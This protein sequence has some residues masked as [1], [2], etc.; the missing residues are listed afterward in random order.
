MGVLMRSYTLGGCQY[1]FQELPK[2]KPYLDFDVI[3]E[4]CARHAAA[5]GLS[6]DE[7]FRIHALKIGLDELHARGNTAKQ[8]SAEQES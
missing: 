6:Q 2:N 1:T 3:R 5:E 4:A 7:M 8:S